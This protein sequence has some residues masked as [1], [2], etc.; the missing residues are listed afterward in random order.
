MIDFIIADDSPKNQAG[1]DK[2]FNNVQACYDYL[3]SPRL[4]W[5]SKNGHRPLSRLPE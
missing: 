4:K 2:R 5:S 3:F 1:F